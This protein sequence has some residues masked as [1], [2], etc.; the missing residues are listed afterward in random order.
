VLEHVVHR[1]DVVATLVAGEVHLL[2]RA[3]RD[4]VAAGPP[5][6][7]DIGLELD[8]RA[9]EVE[10]FAQL[11]EVP[12]VAGADV[13]EAAL[14]P[15]EERFVLVGP[16]LGPEVHEPGREAP[17]VIVECVVVGGIEIHQIS[18]GRSG[19]EELGLAGHAAPHVERLR[20]RDAV[21]EV[22]HVVAVRPDRER[23][24]GRAPGRS[25]RGPIRMGQR[26]GAT[27]CW[28]GHRDPRW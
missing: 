13:E 20:R 11:V 25:R 18:R 14:A 21:L 6:R 16:A 19:K 17:V 9:V 24:A 4:V 27:S 8:A 5:R 1:D 26:S 23:A 3:D 7:G 10:L 22:P 2:E 28:N 15:A 12:A